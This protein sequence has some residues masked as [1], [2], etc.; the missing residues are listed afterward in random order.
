MAD[1]QGDPGTS[2]EFRESVELLYG[3][4][5]SLKFALKKDGKDYTVMP[6]EG[7]FSAD[8][9]S[10]FVEE[11]REEWK[12]T[13]MILQPMEVSVKRLAAAESELVRKRKLSAPLPVRLQTLSEGL[14]VHT[15]H[16]G[17]YAKEGPTIKMLHKY[18]E[19][20][21]YAFNGI[22]HEIYLS[23]PRRV[24]ADKM[25]TVIRQPVMKRA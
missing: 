17:P 15:M 14:C 13:L 2:A 11:R 21:G 22:H 23:D 8:D 1:G 10:A 19:E 6:L 25:R 12:W 18:M 3:L 7:L 24:E 4:S 5:Y 20:G 16:I 9:P